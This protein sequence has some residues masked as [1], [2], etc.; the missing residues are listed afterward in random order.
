M[1][2]SY[3]PVSPTD[4]TPL[5]ANAALFLSTSSTTGLQD[6]IANASVTTS[7]ND[8][9]ITLIDFSDGQNIK[10]VASGGTGGTVYAIIFEIWTAGGANATW[11]LPLTVSNSVT[12]RTV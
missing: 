10:Y 12:A 2:L 6:T 11:T 1:A 7:P 5:L 3:S 8:L 9:L 4:V